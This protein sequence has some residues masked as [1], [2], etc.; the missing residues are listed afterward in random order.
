MEFYFFYA[1]LQSLRLL[2]VSNLLEC[3]GYRSH[4]VGGHLLVSLR[5]GLQ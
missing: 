4:P 3:N 1:R 5:Q 2:P